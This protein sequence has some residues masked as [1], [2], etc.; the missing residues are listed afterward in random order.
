MNGKIGHENFIGSHSL[1]RIIR[2]LLAFGI[3]AHHFLSNHLALAL[4][5]PTCWY[6]S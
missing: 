6:H 3:V 5:L 2:D 4:A 1:V